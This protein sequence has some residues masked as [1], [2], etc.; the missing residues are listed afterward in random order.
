LD[1][2]IFGGF[3]PHQV[4]GNSSAVHY[5]DTI[6][7]A[8]DLVNLGGDYYNTGALACET[9]DEV[10]DFRFGT[11]VDAARRLIEKIDTR[12][13][14]EPFSEDDLLLIPSTQSSYGLVDAGQ[15]YAEIAHYARSG[16]S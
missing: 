16:L 11:H 13:H 3:A 6:R 15:P 12:S 1:N 4:A 5:Q 10:M 9:A 2:S 8:E 14:A 7:H